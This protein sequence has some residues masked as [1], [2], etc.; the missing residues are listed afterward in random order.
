MTTAAEDSAAPSAQ[1]GS[2]LLRRR[3]ADSDAMP[4]LNAVAAR[5]AKS[6]REQIRSLGAGDAALTPGT[7]SELRFD[8]WHRSLG[9]AIL[10]Q[11]ASTAFKGPLLVAVPRIVIRQLVD[12]FY[13]GDGQACSAADEL[14]SSENRLAVRL[15]DRLAASLGKA[16]SLAGEV[17]VTIT[18]RQVTGARPKLPGDESLLVQQFT[19]AAPP[20]AGNPVSCGFSLPAIRELAL[21]QTGQPPARYQP[22]NPRWTAALNDAVGTVALP[23]RSV[24]AR[25][26]IDLARLMTLQPGD[27]IPLSLPRQVPVVV[28]GIEIGCGTIGDAGGRVAIRIEKIAE[29]L[30]HE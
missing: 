3:T 13:G 20:L 30:R 25:P 10:W 29:G 17:T 26:E 8:D 14:T 27:I 16:L 23:V 18:D 11:F 9:N 15:A 12:L 6:L 28:A 1:G 19:F 21:V 2:P 24:L 22:A 5:F 4:L 7:V